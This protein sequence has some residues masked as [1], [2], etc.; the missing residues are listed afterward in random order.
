MA[1]SKRLR[2]EILRRD[3]HACRYCGQSAPDVMLHVDHV[4]P[5]A[6]G[7]ADEP[8]NLVT[9]CVDCNTGKSSTPVDAAIVADVAAD[10]LRWSRAMEIVA[11]GR[12]VARQEARE[13]QNEFLALWCR[14]TIGGEVVE[15]EDDWASSL[16]RFVLAGLDME[17]MEEL[18]AVAMRSRSSE[19]W[20]YF[21]GCCWRRIAESQ[22][23][24]RAIVEMQIARESGELDDIAAVF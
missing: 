19:K 22:E 13:R 4:V 18:I 3:N 20:R 15:L 5:V 2:F 16:D 8:E 17:D 21:C 7:G 24:A 11:T 14:W 10:A 6:L 1:I 23:H 9:A 12:A